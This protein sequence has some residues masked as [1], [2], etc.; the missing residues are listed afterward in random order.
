MAG[1]RSREMLSV[2]SVAGLLGIQPSTVHQW[3]ARGLNPDRPD[4]PEFPEPDC[5]VRT[6]DPNMF[7]LAWELNREPEI[8]AYKEKIDARP[9]HGWRRGQKGSIAYTRIKKKEAAHE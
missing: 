8:H 1:K 9:G 3:I 5:K 7:I 6:S 2:T 4:W